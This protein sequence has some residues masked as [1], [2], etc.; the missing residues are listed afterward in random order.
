MSAQTFASLGSPMVAKCELASGQLSIA[1]DLQ[2]ALR[3]LLF[4][5]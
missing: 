4:G 5:I 1:E 3:R 2:H